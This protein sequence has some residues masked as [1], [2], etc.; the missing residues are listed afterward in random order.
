VSLYLKFISKAKTALVLT[1]DALL[2][3]IF[4][5]AIYVPLATHNELFIPALVLALLFK[6]RIFEPI[7]EHLGLEKF[8]ADIK[9]EKDHYSGGDIVKGALLIEVKKKFVFRE[10]KFSVY[11]K[12]E[13]NIQK[14]VF[15]SRERDLYKSTNIFFSIDLSYILKI[16][17]THV[18]NDRKLEVEPGC[19]NIPFEFVIPKE[20]HDSY[21]GK[22][23][24]VVYE[25]C[26]FVKTRRHLTK[27]HILRVVNCY[28]KP[29][30]NES[31]LWTGNCNSKNVERLRVDLH[32][33]N[34]IFL[35]G[36]VISGKLTLLAGYP[37][38][39]TRYAEITLIGTEYAIA[40]S[41]D[42]KFPI[43]KHKQEIALNS[44]Y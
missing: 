32:N 28:E 41:V 24:S 40:N 12:E 7:I 15:G 10:F 21:N 1:I 35:P 29:L 9:L 5:A 6:R 14:N 30:E 38:K 43:L 34:S 31:L 16:I 18:L 36:S 39:K 2:L 22:F 37:R 44:S 42:T 4:G 20:A 3:I 17:A 19:W 33:D 8:C 11:G 23:A 25:M 13:T 27:R 26:F